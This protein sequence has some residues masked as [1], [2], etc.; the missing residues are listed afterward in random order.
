[1]LILCIVDSVLECGRQDQNGFSLTVFPAT[2]EDGVSEELR[3]LP[4]ILPDRTNRFFIA[5][6]LRHLGP[7]R[8]GVVPAAMIERRSHCAATRHLQIAIG[9]RISDPIPCIA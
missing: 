9:I 5:Q 7:W 6:P 3:T 1:M 2:G 4:I 8:V